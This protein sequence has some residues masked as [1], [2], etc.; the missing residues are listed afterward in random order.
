MKMGSKKRKWLDLLIFLLIYVLA[1]AAGFISSFFI[2]GVILRYFVFDIAATVVTFVFSLIFHNSSVYDPYWSLTPMVMSA[3][4]FIE[5]RA[6]SLW[7]IIFLAAFNLWSARLTVNWITVTTGFSYEDWRYRKYRDENGPFMWFII[8]FCGIHMVPTLVVFA[9][10]L[11]LF[12]IVKHGMN[13]LSLIGVAVILFGVAMEFFAD[14]DMHAFLGETA[15]SKE[16]TVCRRGLWNHSRHPNYLGEISVWT[17]TFLTMLPFAPEKWYYVVGA[18]SVAVLFNVVSI[19]LMEKR[20]L[21]RRADYAEYRKDT[22]RLLLLP[23]KH[24]KAYK[25]HPAGC[26]FLFEFSEE[27]RERSDNR[28]EILDRLIERVYV[29]RVYRVE[30]GLETLLRVGR[31]LVDVFRERFPFYR[32]QLV[33]YRLEVLR[34]RTEIDGCER[35]CHGGERVYCL[36]RGLGGLA[37]GL[38]GG[39]DD[40]DER[41]QGGEHE[42]SHCGQRGG[43]SEL[44]L[45]QVFVVGHCS[46]SRSVLLS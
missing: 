25:K 38:R 2:G 9:G 36:A 40:Y 32:A 12:E 43:H 10:M 3:A 20:Q 15:A 7:Q 4:L 11:P 27:V 1:Y 22:S 31:R 34:H 46:F 23:K 16:K 39:C 29:E 45:L 5:Y 26:S 19:P 41:E 6:F 28:P 14:R 13:A 33:G 17:G 21:A 37:D 24:K 18:V 30:R 42:H 8:N 35:V 44:F